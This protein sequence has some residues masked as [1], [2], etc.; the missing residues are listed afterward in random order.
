MRYLICSLAL[1]LCIGAIRFG[2]KQGF[3]QLGFA[4]GLVICILVGCGFIAIG[5]AV[6]ARDRRRLRAW[7]Q[8]APHDHQQQAQLP[9]SDRDD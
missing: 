9:H 2:L 5:F 6:D 8:E 3:E 1:L 4:P 7:Q